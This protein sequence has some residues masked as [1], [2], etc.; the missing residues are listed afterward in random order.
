LVIVIDASVAVKW[1]IEEHDS[2]FAKQLLLEEQGNLC[3]PDIFVVEVS[4]TLVR[5]A[6]ANKA[7]SEVF[8]TGL[9]HLTD[10]I[11][12]QALVLERRSPGHITDAGYL[13]INLGHPLKDCIYL[14]L[15]MELECE[16]ITADIR[17][18]AKAQSV[19]NRVRVL[20]A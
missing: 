13:A 5:E 7:D 14:A 9:Y 2:N 6:N 17:F 18:A 12:R 15:A 16:L 1:F 10:M 11:D 8:R 3:I 19:W 4:A 20:G